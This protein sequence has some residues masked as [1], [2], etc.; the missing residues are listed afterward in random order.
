MKITR[1]FSPCH[2][3]GNK[4]CHSIES[5]VDSSSQMVIYFKKNLF[6]NIQGIDTYLI[7][8]NCGSEGKDQFLKGSRD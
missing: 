3:L 2:F 5:M 6:A 4:Y 1:G 7:V 8:L